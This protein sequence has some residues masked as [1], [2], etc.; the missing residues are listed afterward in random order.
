MDMSHLVWLYCMACCWLWSC[1]TQLH[2]YFHFQV[3]FF[4]G[5]HIR[6]ESI[7]E[8]LQA[9]DIHASQVRPA[10]D[11]RGAFQ[12]SELFG[13]CWWSR[14]HLMRSVEMESLTQSWLASTQQDK[15]GRAKFAS[16][17]Q[18]LS[19]VETV[20]SL[21]QSRQ[22]TCNNPTRS[23]CWGSSAAGTGAFWE[24]VKI[25]SQKLPKSASN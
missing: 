17:V 2:L 11:E 6:C 20:C 18:L 1:K 10:P 19:Q 25:S 13:K 9:S 22:C 16:V 8:G 5:K 3:G 4:C 14:Q 24:C 15:R 21:L 7:F 12:H 23:Y